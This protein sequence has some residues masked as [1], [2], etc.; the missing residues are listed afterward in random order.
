ML[1]TSSTRLNEWERKDTK[2]GSSWHRIRCR[3]VIMSGHTIHSHENH[4]I[5]FNHHTMRVLFLQQAHPPGHVMEMIIG[6]AQDVVPPT[7]GDSRYLTYIVRSSVLLVC[8]ILTSFPRIV[9]HEH[10]P[11]EIQSIQY[12]GATQARTPWPHPVAQSIHTK[13]PESEISEI[14]SYFLVTA[15]ARSP[16]TDAAYS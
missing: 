1:K 9:R 7:G 12:L 14:P 5:S 10:T 8:G 6:Y 13:I 3:A 2:S 4:I 16:C 11:R 15:V